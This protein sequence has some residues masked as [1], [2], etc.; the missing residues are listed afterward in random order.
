MISHI[1]NGSHRR[2]AYYE[3]WYFHFVAEDGTA[4]NMVLHET[5]IFGLR[6]E[7]YLSLSILL[8]GREPQY[9]RRNL[10]G[11]EIAQERPHLRV[12]EG[13][14]SET[15]QAMTFDISFSGGD[16][17][18]SAGR[19]SGEI[20]KLAPPLAIDRGVLYQDAVTGR[21]SHWVVQVPHSTFTAILQLG[22]QALRLAGTAY[23]DHQWGTLP[24]QAFVSDWVWGHF[25]DG[26]T[27]VLFFQILIQAG[28]SVER[29]AVF[30]EGGRYIGTRLGENY[31][32]TL[33]TAEAP[34]QFAGEVGISFFE[35][36]AQ[37]AIGLA[38]DKLM[39]QRTNEA[40]DRRLASYLRWATIAEW[41]RGDGRRQLAGITEYL[42]VRLNPDGGVHC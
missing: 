25:S 26:Q 20:V 7:P 3:W 32:D 12:G 40:H 28:R 39:R 38:P 15:E 1:Y 34:E 31:L 10:T 36:Q 29:V 33:F 6:Q 17:H 21:S 11:V 9:F 23:H 37:L 35:G 8:P 42:R 18:S 24:L 2:P 5:D 30:S 22:G 4:V 19:F 16:S 41:G 27:A 13:L 14:I